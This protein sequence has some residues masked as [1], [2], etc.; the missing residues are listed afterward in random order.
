VQVSLGAAVVPAVAL[1]GGPA[2]A[3]SAALGLLSVAFP[4]WLAH[5]SLLRAGDRLPRLIAL[6]ALRVGS[7]LALLLYGARSIPG[8][9][10]WGAVVGLILA[11]KAPWFVLLRKGT[12]T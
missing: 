10:W 4:Q 11:V 6:E 9:A 7:T 5:R 8:F 12:R 3:A 1:M 2:A